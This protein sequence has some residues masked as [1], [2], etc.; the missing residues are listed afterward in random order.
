MSAV[1]TVGLILFGTLA[2]A[3]IA[4]LQ[5]AEMRLVVQDSPLAGFQYYDGSTLWPLLKVGDTLALVR[6]KDNPHDPA[7]IR[8][9]WQGRKIGYVPRR[10]NR[11]LAR[12][13]DYGAAVEAR[14]MALTPSH[15]GRNRIIYEIYVPLR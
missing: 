8:L 7:A 15:N 12:Q 9:E 13:M 11:D 3:D 1:T 14:I 2:C 10:D 5:A 4:R 6:E